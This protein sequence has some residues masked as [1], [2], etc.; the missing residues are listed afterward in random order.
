MAKLTNAEYA[1][2]IGKFTTN[3]DDAAITAIVKH[4]GIA[5]QNR[6]SSLVSGSDP[7]EMARVRD[8]WLKKKLALTED[9]ATLDAAAKAVV[10]RMA[11]AGITFKQRVTVYYLLAEKFG[12]LG[13]L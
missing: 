9:D 12:K 11:D 3:V 10:Q 5:L 8:S 13:S 6:D 4:L 2:E 7:A 1:A